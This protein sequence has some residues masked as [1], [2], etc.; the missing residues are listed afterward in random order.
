M[1]PDLTLDTDCDGCLVNAACTYITGASIRGDRGTGSTRNSTRDSP[2]MFFDSYRLTTVVET[3]GTCSYSVRDVTLTGQVTWDVKTSLSDNDLSQSAAT[4]ICESLALTGCFCNALIVTPSVSA[5][6]TATAT[7]VPSG[8]SSISPTSFESINITASATAAAA[9]S[10]RDVSPRRKIRIAVSV[11]FSVLGCLAGI[12]GVYLVLRHRKKSR[13]L[14]EIPKEHESAENRPS[15]FRKPELD[16]E[17]HRH[18]LEAE[19]DRGELE[20]GSNRQEMIAQEVDNEPRRRSDPQ[21]LRGMERSHV[22][23][24]EHVESV[25]AV[26]SHRG[27]VEPRNEQMKPCNCAFPSSQRPTF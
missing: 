14:K 7:P 13:L 2:F 19:K 20:G 1:M 15:V 10:Q 26:S 6:S 12:C 11:V 16:A 27:L 9:N 24:A 3:E 18:E 17:Q 5:T 23:E 21:E 22:I 8:P 4:A 25:G